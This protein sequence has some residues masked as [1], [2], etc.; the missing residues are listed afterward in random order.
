MNKRIPITQE[1]ISKQKL[2][3]S[4]QL[5]IFLFLNLFLCL[6]DH[7][8]IVRLQQRPKSFTRTALLPWSGKSSQLRHN[9]FIPT[10]KMKTT[11]MKFFAFL[12]TPFQFDLLAAVAQHPGH[13]YFK[14]AEKSIKPSCGLCEASLKYR[15]RYV[16]WL[17]GKILTD[18]YNPKQLTALM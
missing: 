1:I 9:S 6:Q 10:F 4:Y 12:K 11:G 18:K 8:S 13:S 3:L 14:R 2:S 17:V 5:L 15:A 7:M 16:Q